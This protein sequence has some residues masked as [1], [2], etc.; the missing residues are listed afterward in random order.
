MKGFGSRL[1]DL[2]LS[3]LAAVL[4]LAWAWR[5]VKPL[6]P[7][8]VAGVAVVGVARLVLHYRRYW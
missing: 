3:V 8:L 7:V 2:A 5:L 4:L 6:V 1:L